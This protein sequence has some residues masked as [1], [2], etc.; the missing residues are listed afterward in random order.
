M[1]VVEMIPLFKQ[2]A[3][4]T[5]HTAIRIMFFIFVFGLIFPIATF[6]GYHLTLVL[7]N[8]TTLSELKR[9]RDA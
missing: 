5:I 2:E 9:E 6:T 4:P 8:I 3:L 1:L 7:R